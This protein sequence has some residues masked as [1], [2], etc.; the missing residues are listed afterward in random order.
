M[1]TGKSVE[2]SFLELKIKDM[3]MMEM[4]ELLDLCR[5][6][7]LRYE[8][9]QEEIISNLKKH[10]KCLKR[11][12]ISH[13]KSGNKEELQQ[14]D[15]VSPPQSEPPKK[16][17]K[18]TNSNSEVVQ[19]MAP[20]EIAYQKNKERYFKEIQA[21][22]FAKQAT[23]QWVLVSDKHAYLF[24]SRCAAMQHA[25]MNDYVARVGFED[26]YEILLH[27]NQIR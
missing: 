3:E 7:N 20:H 9:T 6:L 19:N 25:T 18:N 4:P 1:T 2:L 5:K 11:R 16:K 24:P 12:S 26:Q 17:Q 22:L 21:K 13:R 15:V 10:R 23:G 14:Q 27:D 8:L